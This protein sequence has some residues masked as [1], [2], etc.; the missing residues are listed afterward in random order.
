MRQG[1]SRAA[2][3]HEKALK[4]KRKLRDRAVQAAESARVARLLQSVMP[5]EDEGRP[6]RP[7]W[8]WSARFTPPAADHVA[9]TGHI[10]GEPVHP[11][12][13]AKLREYVG[14]TERDW[15]IGRARAASTED[16]VAALAGV[17]VQVDPGSF[18]TAAASRISG[19]ALA[20]SWGAAAADPQLPGIVACELWRR[21]CP[22]PPSMEM[23]EDQIQ[24]GYAALEAGDEE[25]AGA[26]WLDTWGD[27]LRRLPPH[28]H[29]FPEASAACPGLQSVENWVQDALMG[30][31]NFAVGH[32]DRAERGLA[33]VRSLRA[34]FTGAESMLV[35]QE[36]FFLEML[37]RR[38]DAEM[39]LR[40]R[41]AEDPDDPMPYAMLSHMLGDRGK[42]ED[43]AAA[44]ALLEAA[45][46]RPVR[47][48]DGW[49]FRR[50]QAELQRRTDG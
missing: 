38:E 41:L 31:N 26:I 50:R 4:R 37:D 10:S 49:D 2:K 19:W 46:R 30:I 36:A 9:R 40:G 18:R 16:L 15:T 12:V 3:K 20:E 24:E 48:A 13:V 7:A 25:R 8:A 21:W 14:W 22:E 17:G 23:I 42:P 35:E 32:P 28:V 39:L 47:N 44:I 6:D 5:W 43:R 33:W 29:T 34:R 1:S 11:Q 45:I 27:L